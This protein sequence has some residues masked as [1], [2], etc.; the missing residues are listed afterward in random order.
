MHVGWHFI[1]L[2]HCLQ[3]C[4]GSICLAYGLESCQCIAGPVDPPTKSCELCCKL[5]GEDQP[6]L[7]ETIIVQYAV[8]RECSCHSFHFAL[9]ETTFTLEIITSSVSREFQLKRFDLVITIFDFQ[10][11][12]GTVGRSWAFPIRTT[13]NIRK[14]LTTYI[15]YIQWL[16]EVFA[17]ILSF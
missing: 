3:E 9:G 4:T 12:F 14:N 11:H 17:H 1:G 6:C 8:L 7:W 2:L 5:P 15:Q 10:F 16:Q 13:M